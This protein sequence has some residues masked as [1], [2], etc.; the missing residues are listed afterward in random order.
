MKFFQDYAH[1]AVCGLIAV[2]LF[3]SFGFGAF[4]MDQQQAPSHATSVAALQ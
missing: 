4:H 2:A 3:F 1:V